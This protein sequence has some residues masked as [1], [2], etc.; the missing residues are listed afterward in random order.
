MEE[1]KKN[2]GHGMGVAA[3]IMGIISFVVAFIPCVGLFALFT[4]VVAIVLGAIGLSQASKSETPKG[5]SLAGLITG[6]LALFIAIAQIAVFAGLS[7]KA[8]FIGDRIEEV[9]E[10]IEGDIRKEIDGGDFH[11]TIED[12][13]QSIEIKG[14]AN[15]KSLLD[16]LDE[17]E[18]VDVKIDFD[19]EE[20]KQDTSDL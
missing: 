15:K 17:L 6:V 4:A 5:M 11:I 3:L 7:D 13:D 10:D 19:E 2:T 8:G 9:I 20:E 16:K 12:G 14:S 1:I 18:D